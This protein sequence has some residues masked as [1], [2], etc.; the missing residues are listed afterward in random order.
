VQEAMSGKPLVLTPLYEASRKKDAAVTAAATFPL[1]KINGPVL[2]LGGKDDQM[3][4][5]SAHCD[6]AMHYFKT[7]HHAYA[8]REI[9]YPDAGHTFI[10]AT[11]GPKSAM[12]SYSW[13]GGSMAFGG[14]A[15]GDAN[16]ATSAWKTI[17]SFLKSSLGS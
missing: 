4:P 7:H 9:N 11:Q 1:E 17:W 14:T 5:S 2:C 8:D 15:Q 16:A 12:L 3:W 10:M 13:P 6:D